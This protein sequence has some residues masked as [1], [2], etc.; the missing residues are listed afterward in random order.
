V[1]K[2][3]FV[4]EERRRPKGHLKTQVLEEATIGG[5]GRVENSHQRRRISKTKLYYVDLN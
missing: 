1:K 4:P 5:K 3:A 2:Y